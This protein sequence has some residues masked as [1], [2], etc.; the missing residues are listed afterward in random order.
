MSDLIGQNFGPIVWALLLGLIGWSI[1]SQR[2]ARTLADEGRCAKCRAVVTET[3][4]AP[5][6][7]G[8]LCLACAEARRRQDRVGVALWGCFIAFFVGALGYGTWESWSVHRTSTREFWE[9]AAIIML[10]GIA[11]PLWVIHRYRLRRDAP[12]QRAEGPASRRTRG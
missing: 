3:V 2:R 6:G 9:F 8:V 11:W 4:L 1:H 5:A 12:K 10:I 7:D